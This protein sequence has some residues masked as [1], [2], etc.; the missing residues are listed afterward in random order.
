M[1]L[2]RKIL[3]AL[4]AAIDRNGP[5]DRR[6]LVS[7]SSDLFNVVNSDKRDIAEFFFY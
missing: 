1:S 6:L 7:R 2:Y 4:L 5:A 3:T